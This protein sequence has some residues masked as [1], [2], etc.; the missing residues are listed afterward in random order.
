MLLVR[1]VGRETEVENSAALEK[2]IGKSNVDHPIATTLRQLKL[3]AI[4][5]KM[6]MTK[7]NLAPR[8]KTNFLGVPRF[9]FSL[10]EIDN[11]ALWIYMAKKGAHK[12]LRGTTRHE[13]T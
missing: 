11:C 12:Q 6:P 3:R 5:P 10:G 13:P 1:I 8:Q 9:L 7:G 2:A 4:L